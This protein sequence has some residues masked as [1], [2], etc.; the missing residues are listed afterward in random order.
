MGPLVPFG[1]VSAEFDFVIAFLI[2]LGFGFVLEQAGFSSSR[3]LAGVFFG[4]DFTVLR[5]FFTAA[6]TAMTG[7]L[8]MST[9]GAIDLGLIFVNSLNLGAGIIG[10]VIMGLGFVIG[11]YCPGTS[12][13]AV[14]IGKLDAMFFVI[15]SILGVF[16]YTELYPVLLPLKTLGA[17]GPVQIHTTLGMPLPVFALILTAV[18]VGAFAFTAYIQQRVNKVPVEDRRKAFRV[19]FKR[20]AP[21]VALL[22]VVGIVL[23]IIPDRQAALQSR[24]NDSIYVANVPKETISTDE[25]AFRL[26]ENPTAFRLVD[27]RSPQE[28]DKENIPTAINMPLDSLIYPRWHKPLI[29]SDKPL[30]LYCRTQR[31]ATKANAL[32]RELGQENIMVLHGGM[33]AFRHDILQAAKPQDMSEQQIKDTYRFRRDASNRLKEMAKEAKTPKAPPVKKARKASGGCG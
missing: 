27:V 28:Y 30:V 3:R 6:V 17:Y 15:G 10:G 4:Y 19:D 16:L 20:Y 13:A 21:F 12:V 5:V 1:I 25:L 8:I 7:L 9:L 31:R 33:K 32:L 22:L 29:D 2:G 23:I 14:A 26:I 11:G 24:I 18:A